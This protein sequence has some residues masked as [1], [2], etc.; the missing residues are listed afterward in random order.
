MNKEE[1]IERIE[2][3]IKILNEAYSLNDLG[4]NWM[5]KLLIIRNFRFSPI[6]E[7]QHKNGRN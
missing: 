1:K 7:V 6:S 2:E 4:K 3:A 5:S